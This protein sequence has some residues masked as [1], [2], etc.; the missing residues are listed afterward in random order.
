MEMVTTEDQDRR[1]QL[2]L[3]LLNYCELDT[4][5]MVK[6]LMQVSEMS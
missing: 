1:E 4:L 5:A 6:I 2:K 3:P